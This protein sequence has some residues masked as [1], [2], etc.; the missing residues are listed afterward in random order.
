MADEPVSDKVNVL[1]LCVIAEF[2]L[3]DGRFIPV[4]VTDV[5]ALLEELGTEMRLDD[6]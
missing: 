2:V 4:S 5:E 1:L 3:E 6:S